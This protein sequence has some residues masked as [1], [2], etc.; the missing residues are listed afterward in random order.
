MQPALVFLGVDERSAPDEAK[1]LPLTKPTETSTL[2]SHSPYG[3]PYWAI[4]ATRLD[5]LKKKAIA[6][7]E[8][9]EF[10]DMRA[11]MQTI[12][13]EEAAIAAEGRALTDWATRNK[14][15]RMPR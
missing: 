6:G 3:I 4:D 14:V 8:G 2:E 10:T 13:G 7:G 1:S 9:F 15:S 11:G 5:K 12:P